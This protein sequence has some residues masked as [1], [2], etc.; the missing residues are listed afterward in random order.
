MEIIPSK[1]KKGDSQESPFFVNK[2]R[3]ATGDI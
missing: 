1:K 2:K 3:V